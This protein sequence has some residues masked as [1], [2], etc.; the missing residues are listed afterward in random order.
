MTNIPNK[1]QNKFEISEKTSFLILYFYINCFV[2][3]LI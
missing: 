1:G 2:H 3:L